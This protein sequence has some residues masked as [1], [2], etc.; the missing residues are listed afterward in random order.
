VP[1]T[2]ESTGCLAPNS[3]N[4]PDMRLLT[5]GRIARHRVQADRLP[6]VP[7]TFVG[8]IHRG[9]ERVPG[10]QFGQRAGYAASQGR[11]DRLPVPPSVDCQHVAW[12]VVWSVLLLFDNKRESR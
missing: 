11:A 6:P 12:Q 2:G 10:T 4:E 1:S 7:P 9:V 8:A 3:A 5:V